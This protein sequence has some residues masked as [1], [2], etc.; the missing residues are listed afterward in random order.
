[1]KQIISSVLMFA[2]ALYGAPLWAAGAVRTHQPQQTVQQLLERS[3]LELFDLASE[4]TISKPLLQQQRRMLEEEKRKEESE[5]KARKKAIEQR[6]S[7]AQDDLKR[8]NRDPSRSPEIEAKRHEL[9]CEIQN[10]RKELQEVELVL[11]RGL[12]T[13]YENL[14]AKLDVLEK[15]PER[16]NQVQEMIAKGENPVGKFGDFR[17]IG[18]RGGPFEGQEQ[19]VRVGREAIEEMRR[20]NILPPEVEDEQIKRYVVDL[21]SRIARHSDLRVPLDVIIL[22]SEEINAFAFPGGFLFVNTG[23]IEKAENEAE[24]AGVLAHEIAHI[25]ARHGNRLMG[26]ANIANIIFQVAQLAALILTGGVASL[27]TYY[28]LQYGFFGLGLVLNLSLLGV[29]RDYEIE[30]D[31]LGTQYL[32]AA[33]YDTRGF[34]SFF[35]KMAQEAGYVTGLSWFR[36]HPPFY[37][38]MEITYSTILYLPAQEDP[39][40]DTKE[41]H[42]IKKRLEEYLEEMKKED[43]EAPTLRRVYDCNDENS[44]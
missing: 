33:N 26:K 32:W 38:R 11:E 1:M 44:D 15:W 10:S 37:E 2:I 7:R 31:I 18:F 14:L 4:V 19:D 30:A 41:F 39:I 29:S 43:R 42:D 3:Y 25:A 36:T 5:L 12:D 21:A 17:D 40:T 16:H 27:A 35:G 8:L 9:H 20:Q 6:I 22:R 28:L 23:L 13:R 34:I 24:L